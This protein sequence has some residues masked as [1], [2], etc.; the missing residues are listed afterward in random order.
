MKSEETS[1]EKIPQS[2][3][4]DSFNLTVE[5]LFSAADVEAVYAKPIKHGD[6]LIIPAAEV[7]CSGGFGMGSG[8]GPHSANGEGNYDTPGSGSGG[9][10]GGY[11]GSRPV[12]VIIAD[13]NGVRVEPVVD[14]TKMALALF[15]T[16]G[17][18]VSMVARMSSSRKFRLKK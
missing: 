15:T 9:G 13:A 11:S 14:P 10:G 16:L 18:M 5:K 8:A 6:T 7:F 4:D 17:F 12:A 1:I 2:S 3:F